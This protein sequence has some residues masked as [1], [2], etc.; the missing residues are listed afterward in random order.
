MENQ[1][2]FFF[3]YITR[4]YRIHSVNNRFMFN[5]SGG[6]FVWDFCVINS[7]TES[8]LKD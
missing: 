8:T 1:N 4:V 5:I 7:N 3:I 6:F 2:N